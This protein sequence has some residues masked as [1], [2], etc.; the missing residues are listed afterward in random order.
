MRSHRLLRFYTLIATFA[1]LLLVAVGCTTGRRAL[2]DLLFLRPD[3][4]GTTQLY[5]QPAHA[6]EATPLTAI[7]PDAPGVA[8]YRLSPD[9]TTVAYATEPEGGSNELRLLNLR[10]G[11]DRPL[12]SCPDAA[13]SEIVWSPD[14]RRLI[15]ER[16]ENAAGAAGPP[17]LWWLDVASGNTLPVIAGDAVPAYGASFSP[18]GRRL[19]YVSP[20]QQSVILASLDGSAQHSVA[21]R[22][23]M[24]P[25]WNR[26]GEGVLVSDLHL[27]VIHAE[28]GDDHASHAHDF[29]SATL[30]FAVGP[31]GD[32][33]RLLSPE[34][35]VDD[36]MPAFSPD[37]AWILFGRRPANTANGRQ[38]WLMR[39]DGSDARP[40]TS[41]P[42]VQHGSPAW[43]PDGNW[44]L[45]QRYDNAQPGALPSVWL[46]EVATGE[47]VE[48]AAEG[49][50]P[51]WIA[52]P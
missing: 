24:P 8:F 29:Q 31:D 23:G 49:F 50:M 4:A 28:E 10:S 22:T 48:V 36:G 18:D 42:S 37:G 43:S 1:C 34:L 12:L 32:E 6:P 39:T 41:E 33:R 45:H 47:A 52:A 30:L 27:V 26:D 5:R 46:L 9:A 13:C 51:S 40:L 19:G 2:P 17:S 3:A 20:A 38:L 15:F 21:S 7:A 14:G 16:R 35:L 44:I 25:V 11:E